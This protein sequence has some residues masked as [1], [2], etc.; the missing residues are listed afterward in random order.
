MKKSLEEI[1][2]YLDEKVNVLLKQHGG[3]VQVCELSDE[4]E[5][6][7]NMS[8]GCQGCAGAKH[9]LKLIVERAIK[10]YDETVKKVVDITDHEAG[11]Q[12]YYKNSD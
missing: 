5:V 7:V 4:G 6:Y 10:G 3:N 8:G 12:P 11:E 2:T 9:T 1:Q